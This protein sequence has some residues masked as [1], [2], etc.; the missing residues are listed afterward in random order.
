MLEKKPR[1]KCFYTDVCYLAE[2]L[3]CYGYKTDCALYTA[4]DDHSA[5]IDEFHKAI[6]GLITKT[7]PLD[8]KAT[9]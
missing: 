7:E 4:I 9:R 3:K 6:N 2:S 5:T 1:V 8:L